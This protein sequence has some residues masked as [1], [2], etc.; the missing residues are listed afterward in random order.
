MEK[1]IERYFGELFNHGRVELVEELLHPEYVNHSPSPGLD[2]GR[3]GVAAT[4]ASVA[5]WSG[6]ESRITPSMS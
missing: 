5:R 1:V 2:P 6:G 3:A 4:S